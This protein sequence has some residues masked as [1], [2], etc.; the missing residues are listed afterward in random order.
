MKRCHLAVIIA[1][2][3]TLMT[4]GIVGATT[5]EYTLNDLYSL[6]LKQAESIKIVEENA[7]IAAASKGKAIAGL[8]PSVSLFYSENRFDEAK[9]AVTGAVVQ[10]ESSRAQGLRVDYRFSLGGREII[11]YRMASAQEQ[12]VRLDIRDAKEAYLLAVGAGF[13][14]L[15]KAKKA[16]DIANTNLHRLGAYMQAAQSRLKVGEVTRTVLLRA[17]SEY[18]GAEADQV[19]AKNA[20]D[21][22]RHS[23]ARMVNIQSD[24]DII[25]QEIA[26]PVEI[27]DISYYRDLALNNRDD[28]KALLMAARIADSAVTHT[29]VAHLPYISLSGIVQKNE[30]NP[31]TASF[32]DETKY[33]TVS[34][35][36]PLFEGGLRYQETAEAIAKRKQ[37]QLAHE[38]LRE[39]ITTEV[40]SV[41]NDL[42]S[43]KSALKYQSAQK[44]FAES[45]YEAVT[46]QFQY[47]LASSLDVIDANTLLLGA[48]RSLLE[49]EYSFLST[50][51]K[52]KRTTGTLLKGINASEEGTISN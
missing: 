49:T 48:Q 33:T 29:R 11:A 52:M 13:Y 45:N 50:I 43:I 15:L 9:Y 37:A 39:E 35:N 41:Y 10:P 44:D 22:V 3:I 31:Q 38:K 19:K 40:S 18:S 1:F 34:I 7:E 20:V 6:A 21:N 27:N 30:Q 46:K 26:A 42:L 8:L 25:E 4:A 14:N 2:A 32:L 51:L 17:Q 36:I 16:E 23:L 47:G 12:K 28:L 5:S 24:F